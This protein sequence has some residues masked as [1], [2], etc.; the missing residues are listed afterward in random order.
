MIEN[1][2]ELV[3]LE[4]V[5]GNQ[6]TT[7]DY[8]NPET[9]YS[10]TYTLDVEVSDNQITQIDFPNGGYLNDDHITPADLDDDGNADVEGEDGKT[11]HVQIE[12]T[13]DP[14]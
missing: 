6:L 1:P 4:S 13:G 12:D 9:D 5:F 10:A 7:V 14:Q 8:N 3:S 2:F 11:Y